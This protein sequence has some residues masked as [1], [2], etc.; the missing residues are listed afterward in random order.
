MMSSTRGIMPTC[1]EMT[2]LLSDAMDRSL[3]F[4]LRMRMYIHLAICTFCQRYHDQLKLL[5]HM[6]RNHGARLDEAQ[7]P[8][9]PSL[10]PEARQRIQRTLEEPRQ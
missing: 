2:R 4:H 9:A 3:P 1:Q 10:S 5:R 8:Q 6:L 7:H